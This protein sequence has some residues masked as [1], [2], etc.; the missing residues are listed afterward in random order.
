M[1]SHRLF[2]G[3]EGGARASLGSML[4]SMFPSGRYEARRAKPSGVHRKKHSGAAGVKSHVRQ[5]P[6]TRYSPTSR[7]RWRAAHLHRCARAQP[8]RISGAPLASR[9]GRCEGPPHSYI[10]MPLDLPNVAATLQRLLRSILEAQEVGTSGGT[11]SGFTP[12][13]GAPPSVA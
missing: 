7:R 12:V 3:H 9:V 10:R 13:Q 11:A 2:Q 1:G 8:S 5:P 6:L 4:H